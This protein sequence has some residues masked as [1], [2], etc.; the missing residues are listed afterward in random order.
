MTE[1]EPIMERQKGFAIVE[2]RVSPVSNANQSL[3]VST[4][5]LKIWWVI[6]SL[7]WIVR[8]RLTVVK[9][10]NPPEIYDLT[11]SSSQN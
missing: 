9:I 3:Q 11:P 4:S 2:H 1:N 10:R 7:E 5:F 8:Y 6:S